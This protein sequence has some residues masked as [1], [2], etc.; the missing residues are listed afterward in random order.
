M[1]DSPDFQG[2]ALDCIRGDRMVFAGLSF[3]LSAG[4]ILILSGPNGSGKSSLIRVMAGLLHPSAGQV[5]R[6]NDDIEDDP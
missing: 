5:M 1:P 4:D 6:K 2:V 3:A